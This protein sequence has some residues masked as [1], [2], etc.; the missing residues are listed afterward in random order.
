MATV[1]PHRRPF[2][3]RFS[4][5]QPEWHDRVGGRDDPLANASGAVRKRTQAEQPLEWS[6]P[7]DDV[8]LP[9]DRRR[10][11]LE[12]EDP[13]A[14]LGHRDEPAR[15]RFGAGCW[16]PSAINAT[17]KPL[18]RPTSPKSCPRP[19]RNRDRLASAS[20]WRIRQTGA[21][22]GRTFGPSGATPAERWTSPLARPMDI[23]CNCLT[24]RSCWRMSGGIPT[25]SVMSGRA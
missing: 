2:S 22:P 6:G 16:P 25:K 3:L 1:E 20:F 8:C 24:A 10:T 5:R 9:L 14:D 23:W 11:V 19:T 15:T 21:I 17:R 18:R 13:A 4:R 12:R 7:L